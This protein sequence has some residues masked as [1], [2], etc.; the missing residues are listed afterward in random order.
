MLVVL[1]WLVDD[2]SE[3]VVARRIDPFS[4]PQISELDILAQLLTG[5]VATVWRH[6][7]VVGIAVNDFLA[8]CSRQG[9]IE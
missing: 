9:Q 7:N 3:R 5:L 2:L 1:G 8:L 4:L 6:G